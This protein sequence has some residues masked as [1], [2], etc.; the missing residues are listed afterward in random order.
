[1]TITAGKLARNLA[2]QGLLIVGAWTIFALFSAS[3]NYLSR[4]Y[5]SHVDWMP[6]FR[7]ALVDCCCWALLT[8]AVFWLAGRLVVRRANWW[9]AIPLLLAASLA[10]AVTHMM[11]FVRLLPL[12]GYRVTAAMMQSV[13]LARLHS[14]LLTCW[15]LFGMRHAIEYY[16]RYRVREL[17]GSRLETRL[18]QA[19]LEVLKMQL[20]P[21]FLF[22][23][24]HAVSALLY[25]D[26]EAADRMIARLSD[27][28]RL[29]LDSAGVQEVSL[30]RELEYLDKYLE[31]EQ[32]RFGDRLEIC[33]DIAPDTLDLVVPNLVLQPLAE[34]AVR[35]GI[36]PRA[37]GG[38][39]EIMAW[40]EGAL[41]R[42]SV[43][44]DGVGVFGPIS[45][46]VGLANTRARLEQ[47]YGDRAQ[48]ELG[49]SPH[50][51]FQSTLTIPAI[52]RSA[53]P[54]AEI[55]ESNHAYSYRG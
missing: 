28:L 6:A 23:T 7:Y 14:N 29:T 49:P 21:H 37:A 20:Q 24:L 26:P 15:V 31:I 17:S 52:V 11:L 46:G 51:G 34:N 25:R 30:R 32:V 10:F 19:Q 3:Q 43:L 12:V 44:D 16:R 47:L 41:L 22:N 2:L 1:M 55:V 45:E 40:R 8:P 13:F 4:A 48:L 50:G 33:R 38:R 42:I 27:F 39:I 54:E 9:W 36:A 53:G 18:A 5:S 35:H